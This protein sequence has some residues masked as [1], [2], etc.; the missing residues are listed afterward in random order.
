ML[1]HMPAVLALRNGLRRSSALP[2][3]QAEREARSD[4]NKMHFV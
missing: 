3:A 4:K 1:K 2:Q